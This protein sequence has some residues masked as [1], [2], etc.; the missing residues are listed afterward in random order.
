[1]IYRMRDIGRYVRNK[2]ILIRIIIIYCAIIVPA[3]INN[4]DSVYRCRGVDI[5]RSKNPKEIFDIHIVDL[6]DLF[7]CSYGISLGISHFVTS[8]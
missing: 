7:N 1:M 4:L 5:D 3:L 6:I 8:I 2:E